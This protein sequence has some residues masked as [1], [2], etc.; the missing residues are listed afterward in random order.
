MTS[1]SSPSQLT[2]A[3]KCVTSGSQFRAAPT[4]SLEPHRLT[5]SVGPIEETEDGC[6][7]LWL[8]MRCPSYSPQYPGQNSDGVHTT[9][10]S[11]TTQT[12]WPLLTPHLCLDRHP[13]SLN[14]Q[15]CQFEVGSPV[16]AVPRAL[17]CLLRFTIPNR[18]SGP[19]GRCPRLATGLLHIL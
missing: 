5:Y 2:L 8:R 6:S 7:G 15:M 17:R 9:S 18:K 19:C 1:L 10:W 11:L 14:H 16:A 3:R 13:L 12:W 4:P